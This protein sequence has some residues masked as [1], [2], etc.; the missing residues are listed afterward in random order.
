MIHRLLFPPWPV[1]AAAIC[2]AILAAGVLAVP[3]P[4]PPFPE[5]YGTMVLDT[6]GEVLHTYLAD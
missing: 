6:H 2:V 1:R 5:D 3:V 4:D